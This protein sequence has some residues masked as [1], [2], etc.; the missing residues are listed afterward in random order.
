MC[1]TSR[2]TRRTRY[3]PIGATGSGADATGRSAFGT[4]EGVERPNRPFSRR[5][6]SRRKIGESSRSSSPTSPLD[7]RARRSADDS[8]VVDSLADSMLT[9]S[10]GSTSEASSGDWSVLPPCVSASFRASELRVFC[11][12]PFDASGRRSSGSSMSSVVTARK[13]TGPIPDRPGAPSIEPWPCPS[14]WHRHLESPVPDRKPSKESTP[15]PRPSSTLGRV[16]E[17]VVRN[18]HRPTRRRS[19]PPLL[20]PRPTDSDALEEVGLQ[21]RGATFRSGFFARLIPGWVV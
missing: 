21:A 16:V 17:A 2:R 19:L 1:R 12:S 10:L 13:S 6:R 14:H 5:G 15:S 11:G 20:H 4:G 7:I 18:R 3:P 8:S 9:S